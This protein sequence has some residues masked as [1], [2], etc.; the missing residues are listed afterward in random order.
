CG[1]V[2]R[3]VS[4]A[5]PEAPA[6]EAPAPRTDEPAPARIEVEL[7]AQQPDLT[8]TVVHRGSDPTKYKWTV[9]TPHLTKYEHGVAH[10]WQLSAEPSVLAKGYMDE[11]EQAND[12]RELL[13][14]L[15]GVGKE[16]FKATP[17]NF[18][19]AFW[20]LKDAGR[21]ETI[22]IVSDEDLIPWELLIP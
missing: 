18:Q 3:R 16:L 6:V 8:I 11:F 21:L 19:D 7:G 4:V 9:T 13:A 1:R 12:S 20:K 2:H 17:P 14:T 10:N 5:G 22:L 15:R